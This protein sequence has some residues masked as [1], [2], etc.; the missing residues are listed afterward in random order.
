MIA[1]LRI[2]IDLGGTKIAAVGLDRQ[3][4]VLARASVPTPNEDYSATIDAIAGLV[5]RIEGEAGR[6]GSIGIGM[7]GSLSPKTGLVQNA[8]STWLN[9][10]PFDRDLEAR[11]ARP[12]RLANDANCFALSEAIDGAG[13]GQHCVF[14]VIIG[15]GCGGGIVVDGRLL[16]GPRHTGGEWGHTPLPWAQADETPGPACWCGRLGCME[17]WV[18]GPAL[19][20]DHKRESGDTLTAQEIAE[21]AETGDAPARASLQRHASRLARGLA[22]IVNII[23]PDVIVLGGGLSQMPHLYERLPE[24]IA[25]FVFSDNT[26]VA[27]QPPVH[28]G[29]SGVRGAAWL[30]GGPQRSATRTSQGSGT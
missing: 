9:G 15:T 16:D 21:R 8:N 12:V 24:L 2:G 14:G 1:P 11:L 18:S 23:D 26:D 27:V 17:C 3:G 7:P 19:A 29:T 4:E 22:A 5:A 25:P 6:Q 28:G 20:Q 10:K 13:A 30:W